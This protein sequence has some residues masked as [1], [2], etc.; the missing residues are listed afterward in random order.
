MRFRTVTLEILRHGPPHNQLLSPLT[1]YLALSGRYQAV[2][3]QLPWEHYRF[4]RDLN[5]LRYGANRGDGPDPAQVTAA[6]R[7]DIANQVSRVFASVPGLI[8]GL[9]PG[10]GARDTLTHLRLISSAS[11]LAMLP[12]ELS[13][14]PGGFPS[15]GDWLS[16]QSVAPLLMTREIRGAPGHGRAWPRVPRVLFAWSE[17]PDQ[18]EVFWQ[19]HLQSLVGALRPWTGKRYAVLP[20]DRTL[21]ELRK[22]LTVLPQASLQDIE[23]ACASGPY[24]HVHIVAHG[25]LIKDGEHKSFSLLLREPGAVGTDRVSG[26]RLAVALTGQFEAPDGD[27]AHFSCPAVVTLAACDS[28]DQW[29]VMQPGSSLV[30]TLHA[31]GIPLVVG[32][33]FPLTSVGA[34]RMTDVLYGDLLAGEDPRVALHHTRRALRTRD[35][36]SHDWASLVAYASLPDSIEADALRTRYEAA[37]QS[38]RITNAQIETLVQAFRDKAVDQAACERALDSLRADVEA[39]ANL[40][41]C[42]QGYEIEGNGLL[43]SSSKRKAQALYGMALAS[44][45]GESRARYARQ[46]VEA[47][48]AAGECY[49]AACRARIAVPGQWKTG[50]PHWVFTQALAVDAALGLNISFD[51]WRNACAA[52]EVDLG[53]NEPLDVAWAHCSLLELHLLRA[54]I[55]DNRLAGAHS[56]R[57]APRLAEQ[58]ATRVA[59]SWRLG[60]YVVESTLRQVRRYLQWWNNVEL[61]GKQLAAVGRVWNDKAWERV[62]PVAG[63]VEQILLRAGR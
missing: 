24:T 50:A 1:Q 10:G 37:A 34:V 15:E 43:G 6:D 38:I 63:E 2:T 30:H 53:S 29:E 41:P 31:A 49:Q 60:N 51:R 8:A 9:A 21:Q 58:S 52:A 40:L 59:E 56:W 26:E 16:T 14:A 55:D 22:Y 13:L 44:T 54:F 36:N 47:L 12:F 42:N 19:A 27:G 57:R 25:G 4:L 35:V 32:S 3:L 62:L 28:A 61:W 7:T 23:R 48:A 18:N 5:V 33:L 17:P 39:N 45:T 46:S 20:N 11:E